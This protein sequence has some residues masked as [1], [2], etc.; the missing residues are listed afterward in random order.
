MEPYVGQILAV[1]FNFAPPGWLPCDGRTL[2]ISEYDVLFAL[3]GTTYGGDGQTN[4]A[5]PSLQGRAALG[6][7]QRL[8]YSNYILGQRG[9]SETVTLS[10]NENPGHSHSLMAAPLAGTTNTPGPGLGL[11]QNAQTAA[12]MYDASAPSV[13]L[14]NRSISTVGGS[15]PHE[16]RQPLLAIY[17]I[18]AVNGIYPQQS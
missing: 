10:S 5:L 3:I 7:G 8:G 9:G 13:N 16:N 1:G 6:Y 4:F 18:I 11:A 14:S 15:L 2:A 17:Y 12:L